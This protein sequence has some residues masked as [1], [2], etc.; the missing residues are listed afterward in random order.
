MIAR[1]RSRAVLRLREH[2]SP[3]RRKVSGAIIELVCDQ[4]LAE[5]P[6]TRIFTLRIYLSVDVSHPASQ[7]HLRYFSKTRIGECCRRTRTPSSTERVGRSAAPSPGSSPAREL[8]CSSPGAPTRSSRW[9]PGTSRP[10]A[11]RWRLPSSTPSKSR[12]LT[13]TP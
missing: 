10:Q 9:S 8:K 11:D 12:P 6:A 5:E 2:E 7:Y 4:D 3:K 13:N 1:L